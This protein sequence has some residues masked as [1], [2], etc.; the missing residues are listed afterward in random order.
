MLSTKN[1]EMLGP[2]V[3]SFC[4]ASRNSI[5]DDTCKEFSLYK[6]EIAIGKANSWSVPFMVFY[7]KT[8]NAYDSA[9]L[10]KEF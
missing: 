4:I 8:L 1:L 7:G 6:S 2:Y 5:R 9:K 10:D 3:R